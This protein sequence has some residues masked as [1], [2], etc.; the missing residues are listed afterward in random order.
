V[1]GNLVTWR[2]KKQNVVVR[3]SAETKFYSVALMICEVMWIKR[4]L[5]DLRVSTPL[6]AKVYCDNKVTISIAHI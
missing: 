5:E 4:L 2:S 6:L 3:S 1:G